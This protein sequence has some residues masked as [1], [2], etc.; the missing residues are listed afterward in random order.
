[1]LLGCSRAAPILSMRTWFGPV[2]TDRARAS[3]GDVALVP[4]EP[5]AF[6]DPADT[7]PFVLKSRHGSMT[8]DEV[9]VPLFVS[10]T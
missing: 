5:V 9:Y 8:P 1:M 3:L 4:F 2:M 10:R 6:D 7:G